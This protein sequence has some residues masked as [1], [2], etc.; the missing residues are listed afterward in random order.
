MLHKLYAKWMFAWETALTSRDTNRVVRPLE[1]G[2]DWLPDLPAPVPQ[3]DLARMVAMNQHL[4]AHSDA[5]FAYSTPTDF[6]LE[7]RA[8]LLFPTNFRPETLEQDAAWRRKAESGDSPPAQFLRFT[9]PVSTRYP[10]TTSSTPAGIPLPPPK[11]NPASPARPSSS[12]PSGTPT[13]S[14]TMPSA[15]LFNRFGVSCPAPVQ[16]LSRHPTPSRDRALRLRRQ[17]QYRPYHRGLPAGRR[18][19]PLLPGLAGAAGLPASSASWAPPSAP[20]YAFIAAA[21]DPSPSGLRLQPRLHL[22]RRCPLDR[23]VHPPHPRGV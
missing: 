16:A 11:R 20:C 12:C 21:H 1:W 7:Q 4:T 3:A 18:R 19:H 13:P 5:F 6:R 14:R 22:V 2:F 9:S 17:R 10:K 23:P 8:P 15:T